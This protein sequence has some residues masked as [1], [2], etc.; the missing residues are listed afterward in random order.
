MNIEAR[1]IIFIE[2]YLRVSDESIISKLEH[3]LKTERKSYMKENCT[4][5]L[6]KTLM[7]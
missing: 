2:D 4:P 5:C 1:K 7:Q 3:L 6:C